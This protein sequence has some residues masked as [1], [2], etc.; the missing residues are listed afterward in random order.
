MYRRAQALHECTRLCMCNV[1]LCASSCLKNRKR[2]HVAEML[3]CLHKGRS[4]LQSCHAPHTIRRKVLS[5]HQTYVGQD[6]TRVTMWSFAKSCSPVLCFCNL[7]L[8][9]LFCEPPLVLQSKYFHSKCH[10]GPCGMLQASRVFRLLGSEAFLQTDRSIALTGLRPYQVK[11]MK[12][13][14]L[15]KNCQKKPVTAVALT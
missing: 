11:D 8:V 7:H 9:L 12:D 13:V 3:V 14:M 5:R 15:Q 2:T 6:G 4:F 10:S 1:C